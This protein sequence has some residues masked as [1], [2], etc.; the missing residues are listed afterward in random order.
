MNLYKSRL[1][2]S[3]TVK[4]VDRKDETLLGNGV[5]SSALGAAPASVTK[6]QLERTMREAFEKGA[7]AGIQKGRELQR[8]ESASAV[9]AAEEAVRQASRLKA[10]IIERSEGDILELAFAIAEKVIQQ[11]VSVNRDIVK[12][13]LK[14]AIESV[15]GRENIRVRCN[16]EDYASLTEMRPELMGSM[17][18][19]GTV[20]FVEDATILRG[21]VKV[22]TA[23]GEVDARIDSQFDVIKKEILS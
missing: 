20:E 17:D 9:K 18:G 1:I 15:Q 23:V 19:V 21:G 11:E 5:G 13:V 8:L 16:P 4:M 22:E 3:E 10:A 6:E 14:K 12:V 2:K 7:A